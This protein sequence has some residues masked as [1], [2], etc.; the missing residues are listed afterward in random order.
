MNTAVPAAPEERLDISLRELY[1]LEREPFYITQ[2]A[3]LQMLLEFEGHAT[4]QWF[5]NLWKEFEN[6]E[7]RF[8]H[9]VTGGDAVLRY[10]RTAAARITRHVRYRGAS[11][12]HGDKFT[13]EV[14][15]EF[16]IGSDG[17][18]TL[19][20]FQNS[21]SE[22]L[23]WTEHR[24]E[25][26]LL[27]GI[28]EELGIPISLKMLRKSLKLVNGKINYWKDSRSGLET[29]IDVH[30]SHKYPGVKTHNQIYHYIWVMPER[31]WRPVYFETLSDGR[32]L[33]HIWAPADAQYDREW[34]IEYICKYM[35]ALILRL[36]T[37][38]LHRL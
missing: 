38:T 12:D 18:I 25:K 13:A 11:G 35:Q 36:S 1:H 29:E 34:L 22:K 14:L 17:E 24:P 33:V 30:P 32:T 31:F 9:E 5:D 21:L 16:I 20:R 2:K 4:G 8:A 15:I 19:R 23:K 26:A 10:I 37:R 3:A 27:R 7:A 28:I 6:Q